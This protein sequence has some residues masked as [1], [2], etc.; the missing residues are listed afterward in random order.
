MEGCG[1]NAKA[2]IQCMVCNH[3]GNKLYCKSEDDYGLPTECGF[4]TKSCV[5]KVAKGN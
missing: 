5:K 1:T 4:K 2:P 3:N